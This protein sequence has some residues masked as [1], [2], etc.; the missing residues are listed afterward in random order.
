MC[1]GSGMARPDLE[2]FT[3]AP[4]IERKIDFEQGDF[5]AEVQHL[6]GEHIAV[7]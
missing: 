7:E 6:E 3:A 5:N 2:M 1:I 4:A